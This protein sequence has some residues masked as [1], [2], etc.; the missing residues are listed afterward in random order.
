M[1]MTP[2]VL[3]IGSQGQIMNGSLLFSRLIDTLI[4]CTI[5]I[6]LGYFV[7]NDQNEISKTKK[8]LS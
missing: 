6:T 4:G 5:A 3:I 2:L 1:I 8:K 7:W